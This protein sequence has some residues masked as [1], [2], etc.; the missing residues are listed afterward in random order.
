MRSIPR[1][2]TVVALLLGVAGCSKKDNKD[3][4]ETQAA[5]PA[6]VAP[7]DKPSAPTEPAEPT[8]T[9]TNAV[10]VTFG[11]DVA[12]APPEFTLKNTISFAVIDR[13]ENDQR[14]RSVSIAYGNYDL[15]DTLSPS[16]TVPYNRPEQPGE[17]AVVVEFHTD[18]TTSTFE[19]ELDAYHKSPLV[20]GTYAGGFGAKTKFFEVGVQAKAGGAILTDGTATITAS[21][22]TRVCGT[23]EAHNDGGTKASGSFNVAVKDRDK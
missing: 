19:Q 5:K 15:R 23:F 6:P 14:G 17:V 3:K 1:V 4:P 18:Q 22:P 9:E 11:T 13:P 12:D 21:T 2:A 7:V 20:P 8:C 10:T 16:S